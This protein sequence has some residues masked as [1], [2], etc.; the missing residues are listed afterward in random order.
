MSWLRQL[1][2]KQRARYDDEYVAG[3]VIIQFVGD[4][5][6]GPL[7]TGGILLKT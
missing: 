1:L 6:E 4:S 2:N 7:K 3:T 5:R